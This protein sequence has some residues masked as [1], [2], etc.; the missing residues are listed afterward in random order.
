[1]KFALML[2]LVSLVGIVACWATAPGRSKGSGRSAGPKVGE[3]APQFTLT[4]SDGK[5]YSLKQFRGKEA[6]LVAWFPKAFT[7]G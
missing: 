1:M 7:G 6:V 3:Q 5:R 2:M 4:G